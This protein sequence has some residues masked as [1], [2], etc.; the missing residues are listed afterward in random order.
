MRRV[1]LAKEL[2]HTA[3][4]KK[5]SCH[6]ADAVL[7]RSSEIH[8]VCVCVFVCVC[9]YTCGCLSLYLCACTCVCV[10]ICA[11]VCARA[12]FDKW[13]LCLFYFILMYKS[14]H[15]ILCVT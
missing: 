10:C 5:K 13:Y 8:R 15:Q 9:V 4:A 12:G 6:N 14:C 2:S 11:Y 1:T 7:P 3:M